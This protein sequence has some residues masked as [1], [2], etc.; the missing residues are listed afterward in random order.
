MAAALRNIIFASVAALVLAAGFEGAK[1]AWRAV[2]TAGTAAEGK[3]FD[4]SADALA[5]AFNSKAQALHVTERMAL[6]QCKTVQRW[7]CNY[8]LADGLTALTGTSSGARRITDVYL[9]WSVSPGTSD[10]FVRAAD[11]L[12]SLFSSRATADERQV[13]LDTLTA[14]VNRRSNEWAGKMTLHGVDYQLCGSDLLVVLVVSGSRSC[15]DLR[16]A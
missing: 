5:S 8:R 15:E 4:M 16:K 7:V 1:V 9:F 6:E 2:L 12:L 13:A 14:G 3:S 11:I 10:S